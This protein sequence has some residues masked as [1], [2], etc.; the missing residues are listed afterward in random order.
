VDALLDGLDSRF[1]LCFEDENFIISAVSFPQFLTRRYSGESMQ[2]RV[3]NL[4]N[5]E[6]S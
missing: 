5:V 2:N 4:L 3:R 1:G 6:V